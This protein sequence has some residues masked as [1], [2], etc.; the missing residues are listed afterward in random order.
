MNET[1]H[2]L[3]IHGGMLITGASALLAVGGVAL[4]LHRAPINRQ[5]AGELTIVAVMAWMIIACIPLPRF[6]TS[7]LLPQTPLPTI[8]TQIPEEATIADPPIPA[9]IAQERL[10]DEAAR[11]HETAEILEQ[12]AQLD[13]EHPVLPLVDSDLP[14]KDS[15]PTFEANV[16]V[17]AAPMIAPSSPGAA[18]AVEGFSWRQIVAA[19]YLGGAA[20][21]VAWVVLGW[22]LLFRLTR[23]AISPH[24]WLQDLYTSLSS[25]PL[26][27]LLVSSKCRRAF[28]C[29]WWRPTI[30]LPLECCEESRADQLRQIL[31]H[32]LAHLQQGDQRGRVLFNLALPLLY[33][34]PLYWW[35]RSRTYLAAELVADDWAAGHS[36][37]TAYAGELIALV[38][39][40]GRRGMAHVGTVGIFSSPTQFYRRMEMLVRRQTP[41]MTTCTRRWRL[42]TTL[43]AAVAVLLLSSTLGVRLVQAEPDDG[44]KPVET[45]EAAPDAQANPPNT[46]TPVSVDVPDV[47]EK[48][49]DTIE[50]TPDARATPA[51]PVDDR[52]REIFGLGGRRAD[53]DGEFGG[54]GNGLLR[55]GD[56]KVAKPGTALPKKRSHNPFRNGRRWGE[57]VV[58]PDEMLAVL[59][60]M[61]RDILIMRL[62]LI[63]RQVTDKEREISK[64]LTDVDSSDREIIERLYKNI[65]RRPINEAELPLVQEIMK[66]SDNRK[67]SILRV[68]ESM[69]ML[70]NA[71]SAAL[72]TLNLESLLPDFEGQVQKLTQAITNLPANINPDDKAS[73]TVRKALD[74]PGA[75]TWNQ[76]I[77]VLLNNYKTATINTEGLKITMAELAKNDK[78]LQKQQGG[79]DVSRYWDGTPKTPSTTAKPTAD[80]SWHDQT[81]K[82]GPVATPPKRGTRT[83]IKRVPV[84]VARETPDGET[85]YETGFVAETV[86]VPANNTYPQGT[87]VP[88][89]ISESAEAYKP[90]QPDTPTDNASRPSAKQTLIPI[91]RRKPSVPTKP[92]QI[93]P[94]P[95]S[96]PLP[97]THHDVI[98]LATDY[99][100]THSELDS[101]KRAYERVQKLN[102]RGVVPQAEYEKAAEKLASMR[103]RLK[104]MQTIAEILQESLEAELNALKLEMNQADKTKDEVRKA[105]LHTRY[106]R[107]AGDLR[108]L[109][110]MK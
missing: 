71:A 61:H 106:T 74:F 47:G 14:L 1:L 39:E 25:D 82:P 4:L 49:S 105:Q 85:V 11:I 42:L 28:S 37:T 103:E 77:E 54:E 59:K 80:H 9:A 69:G 21:C 33:V 97:S 55:I 3:E 94:V 57:D 31:L 50:E 17:V 90:P 70:D 79:S 100:Q 101:A 18:L 96:P 78:E 52:V 27:R 62:Q 84:K 23:L 24:G 67:D 75:A 60:S 2:F 22:L 72:L 29:G 48:Q 66:L 45:V 91:P 89:E 68:M 98:K 43:T 38:K 35:I 6:S 12:L 63:N 41:L 19:L 76:V 65:L 108:I 26:P 102:E 87:P 36:S 30:V 7:E 110:T 93:E 8:A 10:A 53:D 34:H 83:V 32:E 104:T 58:K 44:D 5:R 88:G 99:S 51:K 64:L 40:Q 15:P 109:K 81:P 95:D 107:V 86:I 20:L 56:G 92:G 16:A 46:E 73:E 13:A